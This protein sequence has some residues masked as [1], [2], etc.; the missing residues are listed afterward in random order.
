LEC[1]SH[2]VITR[3]RVEWAGRLSREMIA[4]GFAHDRQAKHD[5]YNAT[6]FESES[7]QTLVMPNSSRKEGLAARIKKWWSGDG[8]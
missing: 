5:Y 8:I 7:N 2:Y 4:A 3:N 6:V 1:Q